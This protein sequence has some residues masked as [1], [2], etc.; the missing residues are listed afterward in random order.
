MSVRPSSPIRSAMSVAPPMRQHLP[1]NSFGSR[2][3]AAAISFASAR[4]CLVGHGV[5]PSFA[6]KNGVSLRRPKVHSLA[7]TV[8][9]RSCHVV[10]S[11]SYVH[12]ASSPQ[13]P[14]LRRRR[15][16][17]GVGLCRT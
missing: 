8:C 10:R 6:V 1:P 16:G 17:I 15:T 4:E 9:S 2:P 7:A 13:L 5:T 12:M 11:A 3:T 14:P